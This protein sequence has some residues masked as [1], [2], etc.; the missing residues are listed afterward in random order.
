M[1]TQQEIEYYRNRYQRM[2]KERFLAANAIALVTHFLTQPFDLIKVRSQMLQEGKT[3]SGMGIQ[4][5][6]NTYR[7]FEE[8]NQ[9]GAGYRYWYTSWEGFLA[10]TLTYTTARVSCY[11]WFLD[12]LNHDPRRYA[13][14]DR[15]VMAGIAGGLIAGILTNPIEIVYAR[16]QV[17]DIYPKEYR[18]NY[19][20]FYEGFLKTAEEGALFRGCIPNG[21][22]IAGL[23]SGAYALHDWFKEN[24][25]Y[26]LGP[27]MVN[28]IVATL[29]A[30]GVAT[31][32]SMPFDTL[33]MR[34]YTQRQLPNGAWPYNGL[35]DC[36]SKI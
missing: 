25:Y 2:N 23:I 27:I 26:F 22:R 21:A 29:V 28:R 24:A 15:Q 33:R 30:S 17:D 1:P 12:R 11:L 3:Y 31:A 32:A 18:R 10:R 16:M 5:G 8:I 36:F 20:S 19:K 9:S 35:F 4:R 6:F 13:R 14:P 34:L 7:I